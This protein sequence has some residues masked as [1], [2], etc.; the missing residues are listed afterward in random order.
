MDKKDEKGPTPEQTRK[1]ALQMGALNDL[2]AADLG[3]RETLRDMYNR[4]RAA[5]RSDRNR[6]HK[7]PIPHP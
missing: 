3:I 5:F 1:S 2:P 4:A 6:D 7:P